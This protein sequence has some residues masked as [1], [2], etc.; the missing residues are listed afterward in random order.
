[1]NA[2]LDLDAGLRL[3]LIGAV[4]VVLG[5]IVNWAVSSLAYEPRHF[6]PWSKQ[7][8]HDA[9]S[10][11][12]D[13]V[14]IVGWL[15]LRRKATQ[16]GRGFWIRPLI[17]EL[18]LAAALVGLYAWEVLAGG[19]LPF[20]LPPEALKLPMIAEPLNYQFLGHALLA[21][22]MLAASLIDV[23]EKM[24]PDSIVVPGTL[25][26]LALVAWMPWTL[27]PIDADPQ[28]GVAIL[29]ATYG[30]RDI[31]AREAF[32]RNFPNWISLA[33]GSFCYLLWCGGLLYR[34]WRTSRGFGVAARL[35]ITRM[36][37]DR[38]TPWIV[39]LACTG[40]GLIGTVWTYD[41]VRWLGLISSLVGMAAGGGIVWVTRNVAGWALGRQAMGFGDV[42]LM[43]MIGAMVGWQASVLIFFAA[44]VA[45][46]LVHGILWFTTRRDELPYGP[47]L[48]LSTVAVV[49]G[50]RWVWEFVEPRFAIAWLIPAVLVVGFILLGIILALLQMIRSR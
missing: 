2:W 10:S 21:T 36:R 33:I 43:S 14:P 47:Y 31:A 28:F 19:L 27:L 12:V 23:D 15:R 32:N 20:P 3:A 44:P 24:I 35:L 40:L 8:P 18:G 46:L 37:Q 7:H 30:V 22:F 38:H 17:V 26:G 49:V 4:G 5:A 34:P 45:A 41:D 25:F 29:R 1:M 6:S 9:R 39:L 13:F 50:W 42:T 11:F 16:L 48:C